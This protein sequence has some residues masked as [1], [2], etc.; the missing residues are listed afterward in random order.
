MNSKEII[1]G[2]KHKISFST[3]LFCMTLAFEPLMFFVLSDPSQSGFAITLSRFIQIWNGLYF[4]SFLIK[5][6]LNL[7]NPLYRYYS[8]YFGYVLVGLLSSLLGL[9]FY[10]SYT[11]INYKVNVDITS[12]MSLFIRGAYTRP[13]LEVLIAVYYFVYFLILPSYIIKSYDELKYLMD[14]LV[15]VFKINLV[16]GLFDVLQY[17]LTGVNFIP[18]HL[19]DSSFVELGTRYHGF[20]GEP[21]DA[22]PYLVFGLAIY[23]LRS[24][25][26]NCPPPS[27]SV[28]GLTTLALLLTQSASGVIGVGIAL[29]IFT[30]IEFKLDFAKNIKIVIVLILGVSAVTLTIFSSNRIMDYIEAADDLYYLLNAGYELNPFMFS[31]SNNIFPLWQLFKYLSDFNIFP[32]IFGFGFG[33]AS[34]I[35]NNLGGFGELVNPQSNAV[36]LFYEVGFLGV[37]FYVKSQ[38]LLIQSA[39]KNFLNAN[40]RFFYFLAILLAGGCLGHRS[41]TIFILCGIALVFISIERTISQSP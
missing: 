22:F 3:K 41:T 36:R 17:L 18:R 14:I 9:I 28:I 16:V 39:S 21:R 2:K 6:G 10:E 38:I 5:K 7:P 34:F 1:Q 26:F 27:K 4:V 19:V 37:W 24:L 11:I 32:L 29:L 15:N 20:A 25:L 31:Q 35:N 8:N 13:F 12:N 30:L 40:G 33:S 23:S